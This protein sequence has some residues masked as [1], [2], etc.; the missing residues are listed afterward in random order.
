VI[1]NLIGNARDAMQDVG[2]LTIET[3]NYSLDRATEGY[4]RIPKGD[5]VRLTVSDTGRGIPK[6]LLPD[7]FDPFVT[8]KTSDA[9]RGSG[10]GLSVV[11]AV[12]KDHNGIVDLSTVEGQGTSFYTYFP[13]TA[14][15]VEMSIS[16]EVVGGTER[17]LVIDDDEVQRQ[18]AATLLRKLGYQATAVESGERALELLKDQP[19]DLLLLDM[20]MPR[21]IDGVETYRRALHINSSQ[22]AIVVSG[23]AESERVQAALQMGA[24]G[25]VR[26]PLTLEAVAA[27]VRGCLD[28]VAQVC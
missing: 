23:F 3:E 27:A 11:D 21:G 19:Q 24:G 12:V 13:I 17:I 15:V 25:F 1:A 18:V 22:A 7:I 16:Q 4:G 26:K 9:K 2:E 8:S 6:E 14:D 20:V 28:R 10:L 5:Y